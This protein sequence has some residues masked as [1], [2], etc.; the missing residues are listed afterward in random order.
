MRA[1]N[2]SW[3]EKAVFYNIYPQ[4]FYD[5][6]GDGIGDLK[7]VTEKLD[8]IQEMG[9]N[10]IWLNPFY[11]SPFR[12]GGYDVT[13]FYKVAGRYGTMEDFLELTRRAHERGIKVC[14]DLV[15]GHTSLEC[16][17]FQKSALPKKNE[18][19]NRYICKQC[20]E[21][22]FFG[23]TAQNCNVC[24]AL[25]EPPI[26]LVCESSKTPG[27]R[28]FNGTEVW[29]ADLWGDQTNYQ[30]FEVVV[31]EF[32]KKYGLRCTGSQTVTVELTNGQSRDFICGETIPIFMDAV[33][34]VGKYTLTFIGGQAK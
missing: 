26:K 20:G 9:F 4:S 14:V 31:S 12:D 34:K 21:E 19:S 30:L 10:A 27:V 25:L 15:A 17:W 16:E 22:H 11:E 7:G 1:T 24:G 3:L 33:L 29:T 32:D 6:N 28:L 18:Y 2:V 23:G 5:A 8:Y 13:D